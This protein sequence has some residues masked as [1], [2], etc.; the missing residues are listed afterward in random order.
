[1][2]LPLQESANRRH[3]ESLIRPVCDGRVAHQ[4]AQESGG[5]EF[6]PLNHPSF[7][8]EPRQTTG[9]VLVPWRFEH[10]F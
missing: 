5:K 9:F 8:Y 3:F 7:T 6:L 10:L 2:P 1:M 4:E